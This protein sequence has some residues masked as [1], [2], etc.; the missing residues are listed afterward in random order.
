VH[1]AIWREGSLT[2]AIVLK[3][4]LVSALF[5]SL[6]ALFLYAVRS[7]LSPFI[8]AAFLSYILE[9]VVNA[10]QSTG[11][12]RPRS[13]LLVYLLLACL[14]SLFVV[15]FIPAFVKDIQ[16]LAGQIPRVIGLVQAYAASAKEIVIKYNLPAG[17]ERG[18]INSLLRAEEFLGNL[19]NNAFVYFLSSA[20]AV[21]YIVVAPIIAYYIL[22][23]L[24][25]WRRRALVAMARYPLPYVDLLT[26]VDRVITGF[27]RGQTIVASMVA[28]LVSVSSYI[29]GLKYGAVLGLVAGL[30]EFVPFFGPLFASIPVVVSGLMKSF[31]TG[32]WALAII[33]VIQWLDANI[34]V[35]R[36]TGSRIGLHPL[37]ILF[38]LMAG[39]KLLGFWGLFLG[40]PI[41]GV[42]AAFFRFLRALYP[43]QA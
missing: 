18:V 38:S 30:G 39:G 9:P 23:D 20:T 22:R 24:N 2:N 36:V 17:I 10:V 4:A 28:V 37:W 16:G 15:Y 40:V 34:I 29:L 12:S 8:I 25:H 11:I 7:V 1:G 31:S 35:P 6:G 14:L 32:I 33:L 26:D 19:G 13:I 27:V 42:L 43:G 3:R 21:S 41:A 5:L